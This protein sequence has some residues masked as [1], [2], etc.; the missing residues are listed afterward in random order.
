MK[1]IAFS[2]NILCVLLLLSTAAKAQIINVDKTDTLPYSN[3]AKWDGNIAAG[4]E[5]DKQNSTLYDATNLLDLS[6]Q[7]KK[8]LYIL[9]ASD[10][11]TYNGPQDFLNTGFAHFRLRYNYKAKLHPESFV[12]YQWD[13]KIGIRHRFVAGENLR[14]N[15]LH[16][17]QWEITIATGLM[18]E[19]EV[20]NYAGVDTSKLPA[21][22][23]DVA[24]HVIKSNN[25]LKLEGNLS[26]NSSLKLAVFYQ[27]LFGSFF[28]PRIC[29]VGSFSVDAT[30]HFGISLTYSGIYDSKPI[31]PITKFY[32]TLSNSIVYKL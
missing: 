1:T 18:Y 27:A 16:H 10:R 5:I 25:Y 31:V 32:Y 21:I 2:T 29:T 13:A 12:Q 28:Q 14:Y 19:N 15:L 20:W 4:I 11:F 17:K 30:K 3:K 22:T 9:S 7:K 8:I 6:M 24:T 23:T 26:P